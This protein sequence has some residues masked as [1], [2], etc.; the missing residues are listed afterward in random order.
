[1][2]SPDFSAVRNE[3]AALF[4]DLVDDGVAAQNLPYLPLALSGQ[5][6]IISVED[7]GFRSVLAAMNP[8]VFDLAYRIMVRVNRSAHGA[9]DAQ[10]VFDD[11]RAE[12]I[13]I[14]TNPQQIYTNFEALEIPNGQ[15]ANVFY[16]IYDGQ[17]Y[18]AGEIPVLALNVIC[19]RGET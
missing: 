4:D 5:S 19:Q 13:D 10:D 14:V 3:I 2:S 6:P 8:G 9:A 16:E 15:P 18:I 17:Q 11:V 12:I 1:M 7:A